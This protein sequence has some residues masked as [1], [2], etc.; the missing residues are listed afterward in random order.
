MENFA[1]IQEEILQL[2]DAAH[3][4]DIWAT[5]V[6]DNLAKKGIPTRAEITDAAMA[7]RTKCVLLN[8]GPYIAETVKMLDKILGKNATDPRKER[9]VVA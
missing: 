7:Q 5:Q 9:A 4:P 2:C 1:I 8:K 3:L 6:L